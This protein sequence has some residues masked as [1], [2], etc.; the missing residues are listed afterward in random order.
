[1]ATITLKDIPRS[2]HQALLSDIR[3]HR[4]SL[5]GHLTDSLIDEAKKSVRLNL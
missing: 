3:Q 5:P 2:V 1:M 4:A